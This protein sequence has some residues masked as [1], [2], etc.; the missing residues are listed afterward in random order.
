M[1]Q[2]DVRFLSIDES[3]VRSGLQVLRMEELL[4]QKV[5]ETLADVFGVLFSISSRPLDDFPPRNLRETRDNYIEVRIDVSRGDRYPAYF[6]FPEELALG[7]AHNFMGLENAGLGDDKIK[8]VV[9]EAVRMTVG[10]L[11]GKIDPDAKYAIGAPTAR[12]LEG[13]SPGHLHGASGTCVYETEFGCLWMD[14]SN[15]EKCC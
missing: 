5:F 1:G 14:L 6:F 2:S 11:L 9:G 3:P 7:V 13:F 4:K 10:G 12:R 8:A 15:L